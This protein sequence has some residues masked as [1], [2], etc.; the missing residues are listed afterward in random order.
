MGKEKNKIKFGLKN[1]QLCDYHRDGAGGWNDQEYIQY[2]KEMAGSSSLSLDP[3]GES[4]TFYADDT[5]YAVLSSNS[6]YEGDFESALVPEDVETEVMG[7]ERSRWCVFESS[8]DEQKYIAL[9][10]VFRR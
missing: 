3:S 4:N 7:Q 2:A 10:F 1:T 6:G 5:A 8:T 9:L